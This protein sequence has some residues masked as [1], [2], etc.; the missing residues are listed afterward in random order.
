[1]FI[2]SFLMGFNPCF[3]AEPKLFVLTFSS[4]MLKHLAH[5]VFNDLRGHDKKPNA[6]ILNILARGVVLAPA[7]WLHTF[8]CIRLGNMRAQKVWSWPKRE[9]GHKPWLKNHLRGLDFV[10]SSTRD[11][12]EAITATLERLRAETAADPRI[13]EV[14]IEQANFDLEK[15]RRNLKFNEWKMDT[16][17]NKH[18][19]VQDGSESDALSQEEVI[20][21]AELLNEAGSPGSA[22]TAAASAAAASAAPVIPPWR[23]PRTEAPSSHSA[24]PATP[25]P[26]L[27][28][29]APDLSAAPRTPPT[30]EVDLGEV[31]APTVIGKQKF[32]PA[33]PAFPPPGFV[34]S[35]AP[36][37]VTP[38]VYSVTPAP[39][40]FAPTGYTIPLALDVF[41]NRVVY[42]LRNVVPPKLRD[43]YSLED[44]HS[45]T[46]ANG[47]LSI[48]VPVRNMVKFEIDFSIDLAGCWQTMPMTAY[49][50]TS[51]DA[52]LYILCSGYLRRGPRGQRGNFGVFSA[53][54]A[55]KALEYARPLIQIDDHAYVRSFFELTTVSPKRCQG[56]AG[57]QYVSPEIAC[58]LQAFHFVSSNHLKGDDYLT[59]GRMQNVVRRVVPHL[60]KLVVE[61]WFYDVEHEP[62][63]YDDHTSPDY[64]KDLMDADPSFSDVEDAD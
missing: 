48:R 54:S 40:P 61:P 42:F 62:T 6:Q 28:P 13:A 63:G 47:E 49:H 35:P 31:T 3:Y 25:P 23:K 43:R 4:C 39:P 8:T 45:Y 1:M 26:G 30:G 36:Y 10:L 2:E 17:R 58:E 55:A 33:P 44:I 12:V 34:R 18:L 29:P 24:A 14:R 21:L 19:L 41:K 64:S 59:W 16:L 32:G 37:A 5:H 11:E 22:D 53:A 51:G 38:P 15:A 60:P 7:V 57:Y 9:R 56:L 46:N 20:W 50:G 27:P 52:W